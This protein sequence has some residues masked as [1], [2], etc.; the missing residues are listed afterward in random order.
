MHAGA[1]IAKVVQYT[2][3]FN[4]IELPAQFTKPQKIGLRELDGPL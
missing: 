3:R 1:R 4:D 2:H